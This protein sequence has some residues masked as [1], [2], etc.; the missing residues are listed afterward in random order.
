[1]PK[2]KTRRGAAKRFKIRKSG[3]IKRNRAYGRHLLEHK[4]NKKKRQARGSASV[5]ANGV[6]AIRRQMP[7]G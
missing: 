4:S 6:S 3:T 7:Y 1:M 2:M 5:S